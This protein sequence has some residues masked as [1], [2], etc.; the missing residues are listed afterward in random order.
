MPAVAMV[1]EGGQR[2][3]ALPGQL[4]DVQRVYGSE[5]QGMNLE[6]KNFPHFRSRSLLRLP[7]PCRAQ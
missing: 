6:R 2:I 3:Q 5:Y 4:A 7:Q 1:S